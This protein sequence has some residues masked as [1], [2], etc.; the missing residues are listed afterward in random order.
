MIDRKWFPLIDYSTHAND[1]YDRDLL[2]QYWISLYESVIIFSGGDAAPM[3][4]FQIIFCSLF[5]MVGAILNEN[6]FGQLA[7]ILSSFNLKATIFQEKF[8]MTTSTMKKL[9]L[10]AKLQT[11]VTGYIVYTQSLLDFQNELKSFLNVISPSLRE[12]VIQHIFAE[13]L[14]SN[15]IF[16]FDYSLIMFLTKKLTTQIHMPED[17]IITQGEDGEHFYIIS[18]GKC[19]VQVRDYNS[20]TEI[21]SILT[22]EDIFG[23]IALLLNYKRTATVRTRNYSTIAV[24]NRSTFEDMWQQYF[25]IRNKLKEKL[26]TYSDKMKLFWKTSL[27]SLP[28]LDNLKEEI[29][30]EI[31]Y[32]LKQKYHKEDEIIY[33]TG[34]SVENIYFVSR[35]DRT[36]L[37]LQRT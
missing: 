28:F 11:K 20:I 17:E 6:L 19:S 8:D 3:T 21:I 22:S 5:I 24:V 16:N 32:H 12:E 34:D 30:E 9:S 37:R 33:R 2:Y 10:P 36:H 26:K 35:G 25:K 7:V 13:A 31:A 29:I 1:F 23:E 14:K 27:N 4:S 15:P 18:K